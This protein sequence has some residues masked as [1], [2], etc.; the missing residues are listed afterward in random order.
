MPTDLKHEEISRSLKQIPEEKRLKANG[1]RPQL[2]KKSHQ[3]SLSWS[4]LL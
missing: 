4:V 1:C 2:I 3:D